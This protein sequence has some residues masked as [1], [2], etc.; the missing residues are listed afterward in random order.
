MVRE[1]IHM[2]IYLAAAAITIVVFSI[3]VT[4]G[5][6]ISTEKYGSMTSDLA[7][8]QTQQNDIE[9][10]FLLLNTIHRD[11]SCDIIRYEIDKAANTSSE[12]GEK[13][14]YYDQ[15]IIKNPEFYSLKKNYILNLLQFWSYWEMYKS[16]CNSTVNTVL[17]FYS[18]KDCPDCQAQG[19][20]LSFLKE[21]YPSEIMVFS[22]DKDEE[23]Y[24]LGLVKNVYNVTKS[25]TLV[26]NNKV[27]EG[28][29]DV[30]ELKEI[31]TLS[32]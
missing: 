23:L 2:K 24:S 12:L 15:E 3:G 31:M 19:F 9:V 16:D 1:N 17:Y 10:E 14:S 28:L 27:Y 4:I 5:I 29:L 11:N 8:L 7:N 25:P 6:Y 22:L 18:I 21:R 13:V 32:H 20:V 26:V 30:N